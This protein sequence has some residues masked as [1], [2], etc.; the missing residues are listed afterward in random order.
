VSEPARPAVMHDVARLAGVS[1]QT[2]SRV[3]NNHPN[4]REETRARVRTAIEQL[5]YRHNK[6]ARGLVTRRSGRLGVISI[7]SHLYGPTSTLIGIEQA[8]RQAGYTLTITDIDVAAPEIGAAVESMAEQSVEGIIV[9]APIESLARSVGSIPDGIPVVAVEAGYP[10]LVPLASLDQF[11]GARLLIEHLLELGHET[12]WHV[13]GPQGYLEA[14]ERI[15]GWRASLRAAGRVVPPLLRG[16]WSAASGHAAA[17]ELA[18]H[19]AGPGPGVTAVFAANDQMALG[20]LH[21]LHQRGIRVPEQVSVVGFDDVPESEFMIPPLTTIRQD[22]GAV[23]R[24]GVQLLTDLIEGVRYDP[25]RP[26]RRIAPELV[27]RASSGPASPNRPSAGP[28]ESL[29][30]LPKRD[31]R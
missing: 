7:E 15:E 10:E 14:Q 2:V 31:G 24:L 1:H 16:D 30:V 28:I 27:L 23:G 26:H 29:S 19:A 21:G 13:A 25:A 18:D 20:L 8:A 3:L 12:V 6:L 4:V 17:L 9:I 11:A 5:N 22:F